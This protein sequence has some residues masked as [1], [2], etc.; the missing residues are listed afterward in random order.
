[1]SWT[2]I[3]GQPLAVRL[4]RQAVASGK[5]AHAY[6]F[7]GPEGVGKRTVAMELARAL[8]CQALTAEGAC[9]S[10]LSCAKMTS[11]P[12]VHP[13]LALVQPDGRFIK[14]D[15]MRELQADMYARPNEG[16]VRVA[17]IDAADRMNPEAGNRMLKLLEEPPAHA[18]FLLLTHN[19]AGVLPTIISR[20]QV[21]NFTPLSPEDVT[22]VLQQ[23]WGLEAVQARL[24]A[25]LSGGSIG[26]AVAMSE[27]PAI[28]KRRDD[29]FDL[30]SQL[31][32]LDDFALFGRAEA[33][34]KQKEELDD[35]LDMLL[36][37][38]RDALLIAQT[39]MDRLIM[40]ADRLADVR[41]LA[42][43][44]GANSLLSM[45][46]FV[47]ETRLRLQRNANTRL[48]LDVLLLRL[49]SC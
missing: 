25:A 20:C 17:I 28:A 48:A 18:V 19:L 14:T 6:L 2:A 5:V 34:E 44:Y 38:L 22:A 36:V 13:D 12:P 7:A 21:V 35:W 47:T 31:R 32:E 46:D 29:A 11:V 8:N 9:G 40:N 16:R 49:R 42:H 27:N 39:G 37:W 33:L 30:V 26:R 4:M 1:M 15:Q 23:R 45:L 43:R 3:V 41:A 10:C 24:Y